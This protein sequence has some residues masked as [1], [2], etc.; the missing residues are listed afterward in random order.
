MIIFPMIE[1][2][3]W[4]QRFFSEPPELILEI[5]YHYC[6]RNIILYNFNGVGDFNYQKVLIKYALYR[7]QWTFTYN[8][9]EKIKL[10]VANNIL[11]KKNS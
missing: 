3:S 10:A 1:T 7:K 9:L 5:Y 11:V 8:I 2:S 4:N 6:Y